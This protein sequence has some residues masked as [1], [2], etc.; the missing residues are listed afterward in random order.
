VRKITL[1]NGQIAEVEC[2]SCALT[3]GLIE[4]EGGWQ[5]RRSISMPTRMWHSQ[6]RD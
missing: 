1:A 4:P 3:I 6:S 2:R 5:R